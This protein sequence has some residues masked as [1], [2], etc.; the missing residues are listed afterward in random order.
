MACLYTMP[1][2]D[3]HLS[4]FHN[5]AVVSSAMVDSKVQLS[6]LLTWSKFPEVLRLDYMED[7]IIVI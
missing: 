6:L 7:I 4:W 3:R 1:Y 5:L 2:A